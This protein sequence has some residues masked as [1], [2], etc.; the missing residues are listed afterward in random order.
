[1]EIPQGEGVF[2]PA[3]PV[4]AS[5]GTAQIVYEML[6]NGGAGGDYSVGQSAWAGWLATDPVGTAVFG[7]PEITDAVTADF[8]GSPTSGPAPLTMDF[9]N[10]STG[11][12][13]TCAWDFGDDG[14]SND[15]SDPSHEYTSHGVYTVTLTV[16]GSGG[17]DM[18]TKVGYITVYEPVA[19]DFSGDPTSGPE[20]LTVDFTN[21][22]SGDYY[23]CSWTFGDGDS[24]NN[25]NNPS[26]V[27]SDAGVYDVTL[28]VSGPGGNDTETKT[29]YITVYESVVAD[30]LGDPTSGP[31]PLMVYFTNL[32]TGDYVSC[33]WTFGDG[34]SNNNCN[35]PSHEYS[36]AGVYDV[37]LTV[38]GPGG[39]D[40]ETRQRYIM[41]WQ[42]T[43]HLPLVIRHD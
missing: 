40:A 30:F 22:S 24:S 26:R 27:Y 33:S 18:E 29:E 17:G 20:P 32:S 8:D 6:I 14:T 9:T 31:E 35:N 19:A 41:V 13:G 34:D 3:H 36:D 42:S 7:Y 39:S 5:G 37:T 21:L 38:S 10:L 28:T 15:C 43:V 12:F 16:S 25:C 11:D 2:S 4:P 23:T 1:L